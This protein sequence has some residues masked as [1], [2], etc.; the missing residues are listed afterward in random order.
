[1]S[2][3]TIA[4]RELQALIAAGTTIDLID[5][6]TPE[7]Y[8]RLHAAGAINRPLADLDPERELAARKAPAG[9]ALY[10]ICATGRRSL[11]A[12]E[13][14]AAAGCAHAVWVSGGTEAWEAAGLTVVG[15]PAALPTGVAQEPPAF[16]PLGRRRGVLFT[17]AILAA[18]A[19]WITT[20][21]VPHLPG[22]RLTGVTAGSVL[23]HGGAIDF[24]PT[25]VAASKLKPVVVVYYAVWCAPCAKLEGEL[26]AVLASRGNT[27]TVARIDTD[28]NQGLAR[29]Q[30]I[31][32]IPCVQLWKN[33]HMVAHFTGFMARADIKAWLDQ[34]LL[35][36]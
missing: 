6:R 4:P 29:A 9:D 31:T 30:G 3:S 32:G 5:V 36:P 19:V 15:A 34:G 26:D 28:F 27:I 10:L 13:A 24:T 20:I 7:E 2:I 11:T 21:T 16:V 23:G 35:H 18:I 33:G 22:A 17:L 25:V 14:F 8:A 12:A 1:M